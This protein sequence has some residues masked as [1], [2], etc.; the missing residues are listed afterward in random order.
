MG[1]ESLSVAEKIEMLSQWREDKEA[2][3]RASDEGMH[4]RF[5]PDVLSQIEDALYSLKGE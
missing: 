5:R 2:L 4:G 1:D 3:M